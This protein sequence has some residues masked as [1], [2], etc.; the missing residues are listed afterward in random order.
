MTDNDPKHGERR[1]FG[2]LTFRW[3]DHLETWESA[4]VEIIRLLDGYW[5]ADS[6]RGIDCGPDRKTPDAA[7]RALATA[8]DR[9]AAGLAKLA[10]K[11]RG[12]T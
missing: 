2:G 12:D 6:R 7:L 4:D 10:A 8:L 11:V 3:Q 9:K 1:K 5:V